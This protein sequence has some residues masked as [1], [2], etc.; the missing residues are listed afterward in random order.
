MT[1][2]APE[3]APLPESTR[4][5]TPVQLRLWTELDQLHV[6][7]TYSFRGHLN[8]SQFDLRRHHVIGVTAS[9][10]T[11]LGAA[12]VVTSFLPPVAALC[13]VA[14]AVMTGVLTTSKKADSAAKS[15]AAAHGC[16]R[17]EARFRQA[18]NLKVGVLPDETVRELIDELSAEYNAANS[19]A[20]AIRYS[21]Y[22]AAKTSIKKGEAAGRNVDEAAGER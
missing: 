19:M 21:S 10:L 2:S 18:K 17:S 5:L 9:V 8:D 13:A 16:A 15:L 20:G 1:S 4:A 3:S 7:A 22:L 14:G 11:A 12:G 6:S